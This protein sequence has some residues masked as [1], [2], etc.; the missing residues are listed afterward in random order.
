MSIGENIR[1]YRK[2]KDFTQKK[3]AELSGIATITLQ[4]YESEKR[5]PKIEQLLKI[6]ATLEIDIN[7]L[8]DVDDSPLMKAFKRH[9]GYESE[10]LYQSLKQHS[11]TEDI[12]LQNIDIEVIKL[13]RKLNSEGQAHL[14][15][16]LSDLLKINDYLNPNAINEKS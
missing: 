6:A 12:Q 11:L 4:Q 10:P 7:S 13:F 2:Q 3:L 8:L 16:Y 1:F 5:T 9:P 14:L 15:S